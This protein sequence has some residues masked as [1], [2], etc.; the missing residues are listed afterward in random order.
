MTGAPHRSSTSPKE[1]PI[2]NVATERHP[3]SRDA[4]LARSRCG[5][6]TGITPSIISANASSRLAM[7]NDIHGFE[8]TPPNTD[9]LRPAKRPSSAYTAE[10]PSTYVIVRATTRAR[11]A[12]A[13]ID[14][15]PT[16]A[17]VIGIMAQMHGGT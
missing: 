17:A 8:L 1:T 10:S 6:G 7:R 9:P 14:C 13:P 3:P 5:T 12:A 15:P 4:D 16:I 11:G 2:A